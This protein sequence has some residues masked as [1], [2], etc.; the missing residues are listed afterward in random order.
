MKER[1]RPI[2]N[3]PAGYQPAPPKEFQIWISNRLKYGVMRT[4]K[5]STSH[6]VFVTEI[7]DEHKEIFDAIAEFEKTSCGAAADGRQSG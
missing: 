1:S 3:R 6:A 4:L 5:W 7:D 2:T